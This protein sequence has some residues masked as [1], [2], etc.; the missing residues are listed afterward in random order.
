MSH[1]GV[2]QVDTPDLWSCLSDS[3][4]YLLFPNPTDRARYQINETFT[5]TDQTHQQRNRQT[6]QTF[7][8]AHTPTHTR[9]QIT[10][11]QTK[12]HSNSC[13]DGLLK[14]TTAQE[15]PV[16]TAP[17]AHSERLSPENDRTNRDLISDRYQTLGTATT[18]KR[19]D[20]H[21]SGPVD[22]RN[23]EGWSLEFHLW[24]R[25]DEKWC[26]FSSEA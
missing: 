13:M 11:I 14:G 19:Q 8:H 2:F 7:A 3:D 10:H 6:G 20:R 18:F 24:G 9:T 25:G 26:N 4:R 23:E 12:T 16:L 17:D 22:C 1:S 21:T 5:Q 15:C